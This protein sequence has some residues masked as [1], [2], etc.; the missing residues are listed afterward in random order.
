MMTIVRAADIPA[1]VNGSFHTPEEA[2]Q[3]AERKAAERVLLSLGVADEDTAQCVHLR[4]GKRFLHNDAFGWLRFTGSH[5]APDDS[6]A[7]VER[8]ITETL[9]ARVAAASAADSSDAYAHITRRCIANSARVQG[10]K[11]QLKSLVN[12]ETEEFDH[13]PNYLNCLNGAVNLRTGKI[14]PHSAAQRFMHCTTVGYAPDADQSAWVNWLTEA[15]SPTVCEWLQIAVGYSI[16]GHTREEVLFYLFGPPRSGKGTFTETLLALLGAP[17][18]KEVNFATF[19]AQRTGDSQ[20]FDL[21]PLKPCRYVA[22]SESNTYERFNEAKVKALTGG[23]EIYC[24]HKHKAH[25]NY[26]PQFKIWLSS[27]QPV[28]ADPDDEAVWG[29]LRV[30][31]FPRS[32]LGDEDKFL[33]EAMR[34]PSILEGVLAWA[35]EG[36]TCW[37]ALGRDGLPE[38]EC[39]AKAKA[40]QRAELDNTQVWLDECCRKV[41]GAFAASSSLYQSYESWCKMNGVEPKKQKGFS[42]SLKHKGFIDD[43]ST[44][45]GKLTRGFKSLRL[46]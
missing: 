15:T 12:T 21:A 42:Q 26:R 11:S 7:K 20:N 29:R 40:A 6:D 8:A 31:E 24:A 45:E 14:T 44:V 16:T 10:A 32:H 17:L 35:V 34:S 2:C 9:E 37:Y 5:W 13:D 38:L 1:L 23:N 19:T 36:A 41:D 39:G 30:I 4:F 27:N 22:A 28:N 46:A 25:F 43:R 3:E 18:A 33:K